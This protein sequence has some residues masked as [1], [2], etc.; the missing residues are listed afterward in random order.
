MKNE[1]ITM[2]EMDVKRIT[3]EYHKRKIFENLIGPCISVSMHIIILVILL[4][5]VVNDSKKKKPAPIEVIVVEIE[6]VD[7]DIKEDENDPI[8]DVDDNNNIQSKIPNE[9]S[10]TNEIRNISDIDDNISQTNDGVEA[11]EVLNVNVNGSDLLYNDSL[12][13]RNKGGQ[14]K[15][16][17]TWGADKGGQKA[18]NRALKWLALVQNANGSWGN[19]SPAHTGI[20]L[21]VFLGHGETHTSEKYGETV[22][23]AMRWLSEYSNTDMSSGIKKQKGYG[24]GIATYA[25]CESYAMTKIPFMQ[26]AMEKTIDVIIKGQQQSGGFDYLYAKTDRWDLSVSGWQFQ[27]LKAAL[28][29]GSTN[30]ELKKAIENSASFCRTQAYSNYKFKYSNVSGGPGLGGNMTGV[31][32]VTLQLL[33]YGKSSE[34]T[35]S[36]GTING[37]RLSSYKSVLDQP[38]KW[39]EIASKSLYG[40]YYDTQAIFNSNDSKSETWKEWR[41]TFEKVLMRSQNIE[42]YWEIAG[43]NGEESIGGSSINGRIMT[44]CLCSLQLEVYY[45]YLPTFKLN[46]KIIKPNTA[47]QIDKI[48]ENN[49]KTVY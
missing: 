2:N 23:K 48:G 43:D 30:E 25:I 39:S 11:E 15:L 8:E 19:D 31:G 6:K 22:F 28:I 49:S 18:L 1:E 33:G 47:N 17:D 44:T 41:N 3:D 46:E 27:A 45:R 16:L 32:V 7:L 10:P 12:G 40:W 14:G 34:V 24:H 21:L 35:N 29:A 13:G 9:L 36:L 38:E 20:A 5:V 42:G 37:E 26:L 4:I